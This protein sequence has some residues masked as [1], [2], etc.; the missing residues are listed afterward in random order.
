MRTKGQGQAHF[1]SVLLVDHADTAYLGGL[2]RRVLSLGRRVL[3]AKV[4]GGSHYISLSKTLR[5]P[6]YLRFVA[7]SW[8]QK[9]VISRD[10]G[11]SDGGTLE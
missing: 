11:V 2:V 3:V 10:G 4:C 5:L 8:S 1:A 9:T 7:F 6:W